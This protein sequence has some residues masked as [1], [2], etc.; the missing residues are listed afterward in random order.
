MPYIPRSQRERA[1][2]HPVDVGELTYQLTRKCVEYLGDDYK[3]ADLAE[4]LGALEATKLELYRR[5]V[6]PYENAKCVSAGDVYTD[7]PVG[8]PGYD[9]LSYEEWVTGG[10]P[11]LEDGS[12]FYP[13]LP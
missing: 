3:F 9:D 7:R 11:D 8:R 4:V 6:A 10:Q 5:V 13:D 2:T 1:N 12:S